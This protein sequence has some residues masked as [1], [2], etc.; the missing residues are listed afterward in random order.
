VIYVEGKHA[1][2][3]SNTMLFR[4]ACVLLLMEYIPKFAKRRDIFICEF[5]VALKVCYS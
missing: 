2:C 4:V 5:I 3:V 1:P